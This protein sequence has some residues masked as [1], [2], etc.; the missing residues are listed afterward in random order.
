M[1]MSKIKWPDTIDLPNNWDK[2]KT[3]LGPV[4]A[5]SERNWAKLGKVKID[6]V[7]DST[8]QDPPMCVSMYLGR[9]FGLDGWVN[10]DKYDAIDRLV[11]LGYTQEQ[12]K[13]LVKINDTKSAKQAITKALRLKGYRVPK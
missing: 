4:K 3:D 10:P 13:D 1:S 7:Y 2:M 11:R 9:T 12:A 5:Q 8:I 6:G